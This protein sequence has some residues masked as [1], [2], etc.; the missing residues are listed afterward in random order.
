MGTG[1]ASGAVVPVPVHRAEPS[2]EAV[3]VPSAA[4]IAAMTV[5][6]TVAATAVR[7]TE[8]GTNTVQGTAVAVCLVE[9][10]GGAPTAAP[11]RPGPR[12]AAA[13]AHFAGNETLS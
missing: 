11:V 10:P 13:A 1:S 12:P 2:A 5:T 9:I 6:M 4:H 3:P 8:A 7:L